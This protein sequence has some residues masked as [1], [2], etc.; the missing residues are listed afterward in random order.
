[1]IKSWIA[2]YRPRNI[3][4]TE[5]ALREV[6][7]EITLAGLYRS[8]FFKEAAFYGGT[9]LRIF[10][11]LDRFSEDLDFTLLRKDHHFSFD[12]HL[13]SIRREFDSIGMQVD[14]KQKVKSVST[15]IDSAFLKSDTVWSELVLEGTLPQLQLGRK[16]LVKIKLEIDTHPP[17]GFRTENLLLTKPFSFY[18]NCLIL[19]DLFAGKLHALLFRKW[20]NRVKGRDWYDLEWYLKKDIQVNLNHLTI[21]A[22]ESG[23]WSESAMSMPQLIELLTNRIAV[24]DFGKIRED[25]IRFIPDLKVLDIWSPDYFLQLIRRIKPST[26]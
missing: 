3:Q 17:V 1:M 14:L 11:G 10:H 23:D 21:R 15:A 13:E 18:V 24:V 8:D 19:P 16:P 20:K 12:V 6:M 9:A 4:E 5:R 25:V 22:R 7:Q 26:V 2:A